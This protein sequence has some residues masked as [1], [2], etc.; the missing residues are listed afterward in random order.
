MPRW[1]TALRD[2]VRYGV[3]VFVV[4]LAVAGWWYLRNLLL[5]GELFGTNTMVAI[6]GPRSIDLVRLIVEEWYGFF[7]SFWGVFGWFLMLMWLLFYTVFAIALL[8]TGLSTLL[9]R[10][11]PA[12]T[13]PS[14][15][16]VRP[17][18]PPY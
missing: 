16:D 9:G 4:A 12:A 17:P 1:R 3:V 15:S 8:V 14:S 13:S 7:L 2:I 10:A 6:A 5:Y 11:E 18:L